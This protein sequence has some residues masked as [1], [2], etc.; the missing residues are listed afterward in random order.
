[1]PTNSPPAHPPVPQ[2]ED[3]TTLEEIKKRGEL[4]FYAHYRPLSR[5]AFKSA[6]G[7]WILLSEIFDLDRRDCANAAIAAWD[8]KLERGRGTMDETQI[9]AI[10]DIKRQWRAWKEGKWKHSE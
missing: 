8:E 5:F 2:C 7:K 9:D 1:M 6:S 3:F 10:R 4:H